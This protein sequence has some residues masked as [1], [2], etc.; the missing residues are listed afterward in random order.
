[1]NR[2]HVVLAALVFGVLVSDVAAQTANPAYPRDFGSRN[3]GGPRIGLTFIPGNGELAQTLEDHGIGRVISQ[4]GWHFEHRVIFHDDGPAFV[5]EFIPMLGG[6]EY[7]TVIPSLNFMTGI[8]FPSGFE[9]GMGPNVAFGGKNG[10]SSALTVAV[11]K[12]FD[13]GG[14]SIPLNLALVTN[15]SGNRLSLIVGYAI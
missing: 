9:F 13:Y 5:L 12:T 11:G 7:A 6:V 10:V 15:P 4:F 2:I 8:R 3:L 1:M 14:V